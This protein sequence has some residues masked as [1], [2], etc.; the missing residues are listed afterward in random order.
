[1]PTSHDPQ[2]PQRCVS[3][4]EILERISRRYLLEKQPRGPHCGPARPYRITGAQGSL[5]VITPMSEHFCSSCNRIRVTAD[6][7]ARSCLLADQRLDLRPAL[8]RD[9]QAALC[10]ALEGVVA[11]KGARHR[12]GDAQ[13]RPQPFAMNRIGG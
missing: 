3:G 5:G 1:M 9:D 7:H 8:A 4:A 11:S 10:S 12:L 6:G 13:H 2:W